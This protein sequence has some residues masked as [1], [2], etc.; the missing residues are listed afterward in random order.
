MKQAISLS[1]KIIILL[2]LISTVARYAL[3]SF[4]PSLPAIA[5]AF[6]VPTAKAQL[7]LTFYLLGFSLSQ[8]IY[9]TLSDYY[10]RKKVLLFGLM[11]MMLGNLVSAGAASINILIMARLLSGLGGGACTVLN[12]AIA[13]D[14]FKGAEFAKAWSY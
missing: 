5:Y 9:G 2:C 14:I 8:I 11:I 3:D 6:N 10:G 7:C 12:R 1:N 13:S 4:L